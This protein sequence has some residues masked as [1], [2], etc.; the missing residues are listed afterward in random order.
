MPNRSPKVIR[1]REQEYERISAQRIRTRT[2]E[3]ERINAQHRYTAI[4]TLILTSFTCLGIEAFS[5][6]FEFHIRNPLQASDYM[7]N[8]TKAF[9][10][11]HRH[12]DK[13]SRSF[14]AFE[15]CQVVSGCHLVGVKRPNTWQERHGHSHT[16]GTARICESRR[17]S[18]VAGQAK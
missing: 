12:G 8:A 18:C 3:H 10:E 7:K 9:I 1:I 6:I 13:K 11:V 17:E 2:I 5:S 16:K 14:C 15:A 4:Y